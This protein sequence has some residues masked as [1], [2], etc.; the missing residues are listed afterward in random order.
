MS[1]DEG[2][3]MITLR[4][5]LEGNP[6]YDS[7]FTH[8]GPFYYAYEWFLHSLLSVPLTH[9]ATRMIC[10]FHWLG[11]AT[12]LGWAGGLLM[13]SFL[14]GVFVFLQALLHL[15]ALANEPGHPQE[16]IVLL[17]ALSVVVVVRSKSRAPSSQPARSFQILAVITA[18]LACTKINVGIF[19][20]ISLLLVMRC[21]AMERFSR[22]RWLWLQIGFCGLLPFALMRPQLS[23]EWCC[24][25]ATVT[26]CS[27]GLCLFFASKMS[28]AFSRVSGTPERIS[29]PFPLPLLAW[30]ALLFI[31]SSIVILAIPVCTGTSIK[32]LIDG[33]FLTPLKL[34]GVALLP[35]VVPRLALVNAAAAVGVGIM[36]AVSG[37]GLLPRTKSASPPKL[38]RR[39]ILSL[40]FVFGLAGSLCLLGNPKLQFVFLLPWL[41]LVLIPFAGDREWTR[42][43][44]FGRMFICLASVWKSLQAYPIAGTQVATATILWVL[45]YTICLYDAVTA[46]R[47]PALTFFWRRGS[48]WNTHQIAFGVAVVYLSASLCWKLAIARREY[49]SL[50]ALALPGSRFVHMDFESTA[51]YRT[52]SQY[53]ETE[54]DTFVSYPGINSLYF[55]ANKR[56]PTHLNST[57]WGPL[58]HAQQ[59]QILDALR[60]APRPLLVVVAA[61]ADG[62]TQYAPPELSPLIH[63]VNHDCTEVKRIGRFILFRPK[64]PSE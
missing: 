16:L 3:L 30:S 28:P 42:A 53:L 26:A 7:V 1:P 15:T 18:A 38:P 52:L 41:W 14:L 27:I 4:S 21:I 17:L 8:Y 43:E 57:G 9:D 50:P 34:P 48:V 6:L 20:G 55:W 31:G 64:P 56:P 63:F 35:L 59:K 39:L 60:K 45:A 13:R 33:L 24:N 49:G 58:T 22:G 23:A 10:I 54:C 47:S 5:F 36:V 62:W 51:M 25:Y 44:S 29:S 37:L 19:F 11:A 32:G 2:Y 40:K 61:A 46:V 12:L